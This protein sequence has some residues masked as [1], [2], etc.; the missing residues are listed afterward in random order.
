MRIIRHLCISLLLLLCTQM[1]GQEFVN[2]AAK[3]VRIEGRLPYFTR[4]FALGDQFKDSVYT[5]QIRYPEFTEMPI[6]EV[7]KLRMLADSVLPAFPRIN[8]RIVVDRKRGALEVN[9]CPL[10]HRNGKWLILSSFM[11]S[12]EARRKKSSAVQ[13]KAITR[14]PKSSLPYADHSVLA[15]GRWAKIR[16]KDNGVHRL[17]D[18]VIRRAG[19]THPEKVKIYGYGG[20]LQNEILTANDL[21]EYDD[22][23]EIPTCIVGGQRLFYGRGT[24][25]WADRKTTIRTRNPYSDYGYYFITESDAAPLTVDSTAFLA[26]FYPSAADYHIL[27]EVDNYAWYQGGRNLFEDIPIAKGTSHTFNVKAPGHQ[28]R[29]VLSVAVTAGT[30]SEAVIT[31]NG[32][33][34]GTASM[35][36][37]DSEADTYEKGKETVVTLP[38]DNLTTDNAVT[39]STTAGGPVRLDYISITFDTPKPAPRLAVDAFPAAE[40]VHNITPQDR[41]AD[42]ACDMVIIIPTSQKLLE[43]ARRLAA[44]HERHDGLRVRIVPADELLNEFSSGTPD[45]NAYRR[46]LKMLYDRAEKAEDLPRYLLLFGD[47]AWDNRMNTA[48]WAATKPE[49]YLLC[50]ESENSFNKVSCYVDDGFFCLLDDGE[51]GDL[52]QTDKQDVAVGRFPVVDPDDAKTLVDKTIAYASNANAGPWQN[53]LL[54]MGDDG[55]ANLHMKD[56]DDAAEQAATGHPGYVVR[57][58]MWDAYRRESS[59]TGFTYPDVERTIKQQQT[60][61]ALIM[62]YAGHG[63]EDVISHES[64]LKLTDFERFTNKNLPLWITASCDIMPFDGAVPTIGE[65]AILNKRGG[66]VAFY[67]TTRTV[68]ADR[69]RVINMAFLRYV[70]GK[71]DGKPIPIGEAQRLAKNELIT[72][73]QDLTTNKLQYALLGDPAL[74]LN[75]PTLRAVI[76]SVNDVPTASATAI[77]RLRAGTVATVKGHIEGVSNF[78]GIVTALVRDKRELITCRLNDNS[79]SGA[80][81]PFTYHDRTRTIF[82]GSDSVRGSR[83]TFSFAIPK[84][85]DYTEGAGLI[86]VYAV[87]TGRTMTAH[88]SSDRF[89]IG[90]SGISSTDSIGPAIYCYLNSPSFTNGGK[91]NSTPYFVAQLRDESGLNVSGSSIGHDLQLTIDGLAAQSYVLNDRFTYDFNSYTAGSVAFNIPMLTPGKHELTFRAWDVLNNSSTT[92]LSFTVVEGLEPSLF[93]IGCTENPASTTTGFIINHDRTGSEIDVLIEVFDL[94]GCPLW[95][96]QE[97]GVSTSGTYTVPWNLTADNGNRLE[98]GVYLYRVS[99][100]CNGSH[101]VSKARKL[102]ITSN[103]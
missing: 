69:N 39:V 61:G 36:W 41:H 99:I 53:T 21:T 89:L 84:D 26:S 88:G 2:L 72:T 96:H 74:A 52:Q 40:Y 50:Y 13:A 12:I 82:N 80:S 98:T 65:A 67:G 47:C 37:T 91:V 57:K 5:V 1:Q 100:A 22:L 73:E 33:R 43:Q 25:S 103:K 76:D 19:F 42:A 16:V 6:A 45:A 17:T 70:L 34:I 97:R 48:H 23:K 54:F 85:I 92:R 27:H 31:C 60:D 77:A 35:T 83:F 18:E 51:G 38:V 64:V 44:F 7:K 93:S 9:F 20:H 95:T 29:G 63:R 58:V 10:V 32:T 101:Y 24:V 62:D 11:I 94:N 46:Y 56:A 102:I 49:D 55:N 79:K 75:Q 78:Q 30:T 14:S 87:N 3:D 68:Y 28:S 4:S 59:S 71:K 90:G 86:N 15:S 66:A 81:S 8:R